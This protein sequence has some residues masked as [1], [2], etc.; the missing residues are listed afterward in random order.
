M[1]NIFLKSL[2]N[3]LFIL[4]CC[5]VSLSGRAQQLLKQTDMGRFGIPA[6]NYSGLVHLAVDSFAVIDDKSEVDGFYIF[7]IHQNEND[8][9]IE[10]VSRGNLKGDRAA[11]STDL[12]RAHADCEDITFVPEWGT[13]FIASEGLQEVYEYDGA[14]HRTGRKLNIPEQ[15]ALKN[16]RSNC[17]FEALTF[18][19]HTGLFW[20]TSE[21][22]LPKDGGD[23][24]GIVRLQSFEKNLEPDHQWAYRM[25]SPQLQPGQYYAH[26]IPAM[27]ALDD[28][29]LLVMERELTVPPAYLGAQTHIRV[30]VVN[31]D[32]TKSI[33]TD[34]DLKTLSDD[35]ILSKKELFSFS[36]YLNLGQLNYGNYEG[37]SWGTRLRDGRRTLLLVCD[38]QA[39]AGNIFYHLKDYLKVVVLPEDF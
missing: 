2:G 8:G 11:L 35:Q 32:R 18:N 16:I 10:F 12:Q 29:R 7:H 36:T 30:F 20:L 26:G 17:G 15:F 13:Y 21:T 3:A 33:T 27:L 38:S 34:T 28:G 14:G 5:C 1:R 9:H 31:P 22:P 39:G 19:E 24:V 4:L 6:A 23:S 25:E 37:M